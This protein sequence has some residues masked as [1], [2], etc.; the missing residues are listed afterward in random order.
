MATVKSFLILLAACF[1]FLTY[2]QKSGYV[3][4]PCGSECDLK[5]HDAAGSCP[6]CNMPLVDQSLV[7]FTNLTPKEFCARIASNPNA[8]IL[9]VRSPAEFAGTSS[10]SNGFG[11]F[12][13]AI[14]INITELES[15]IGELAKYKDQ[16]ILV[17]CSHSRR[18]PRAS[19]LLGL[20]GFKNVKNMSGGVSTIG[21]LS[22]EDCLKDQYVVHKN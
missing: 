22:Q 3:C 19:Y 13:K 20:Q 21:E 9:D 15:R 11:H 12:R 18:S 8:V 2:G 10:L 5:V 17:Y 16:E 6:V 14:N 7:K 4:Q 1:A